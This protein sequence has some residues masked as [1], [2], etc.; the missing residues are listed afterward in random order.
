MKKHAI[1]AWLSIILTMQLFAQDQD[2]NWVIGEGPTM[3][4]FFNTD[5]IYDYEVSDTLPVF[6][7]VA[8]I[9][10]GQGVFQFY[11]NGIHVRDKYGGLMP[12]GDSLSFNNPQLYAIIYP[13]GAPQDQGMLIIPKP[14][15]D[16]LYY[17]FH[18][19]PTDTSYL[20]LGRVN[21]D[22]L[23]FYYSVVDMSANNG[24]GDVIEKNRRFPLHQLMCSSRLTAAKHG[25]GRDWWIIRHG[26]RDNTY[27]KFLLTP[28]SILGPFFQNI[29]PDFNQNGDVIDFYG[30]SVFNQT[31]DKMATGNYYGPLVVLDF[32]RCSGDFSNPVVINNQLADTTL[33]GIAGLAFSPSGRYLYANNIYELN[34]YDLWAADINDSV[35]IYTVDSTDLAYLHHMQLGPDGKIY[36]DQWNGGSY[37]LHVISHPD[38]LGVTCGFQYRGLSCITPNTTNLPNMVNYR[39]GKL[40]GSPCDT[41]VS[42]IETPNNTTAI[43]IAPNPATD[44]VDIAIKGKQ[45]NALIEVFNSLGQLMVSTAVSNH[46]QLKVSG[47]DKGVYLVRVTDPK[48]K[49][50]H[51]RLIVL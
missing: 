9:S 30:A 10:N 5:S 26:D 25:N 3:R 40:A 50:D 15:S 1:A 49:Q 21:Y 36:I 7:S 34:Q 38:S 4:L 16:S 44:L 41:L 35:R 43:K 39:L 29:G 11:T 6:N 32:D 14:Q 13:A 48:G 22:P 2:V 27:I 24:L 23:F 45:E 12:H 33:Q 37:A 8:S 47:W 18:Y 20:E 19:V 17:I 42:A 46:I 28:D 31:G 51:T